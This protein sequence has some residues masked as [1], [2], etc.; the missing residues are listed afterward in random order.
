MG[1]GA[2]PAGFGSGNEPAE[3]DGVAADIEQRAA[4]GGRVVA[5]IAGFATAGGVVGAEV[6]DATDFAGGDPPVG[7]GDL[8]VKAVHEPFQQ[9][10]AGGAGSGKHAVG[11]GG[12]AGEGFFAEH[13]FAG[14]KGADGPVAMQAIGQRVGDHVHVRVGQQV[15]VGAVSARNII[16]GGGGAGAG[17]VAAGDG[18]QFRV[19]DEWE[20][21]GEFGE[22]AAGAEDAPTEFHGAVVAAGAEVG[23]S[24]SPGKADRV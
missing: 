18:D 15:G 2:N 22:D 13:V 5:G 9:P 7:F 12:G 16:L 3:V 11:F 1:V 17:R 6:E 19:A 20:G 4:A 8:R 14:L 21:G 10:A 23:K 24:A